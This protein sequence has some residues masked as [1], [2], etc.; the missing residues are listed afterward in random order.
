MHYQ[1]T[2]KIKE[3][4]DG[5]FDN[6][7]WMLMHTEKKKEIEE[8]VPYILYALHEVKAISNK[9]KSKRKNTISLFLYAEYGN[10]KNWG[11]YEKPGA[12]Q[13]NDKTV[14]RE[15]AAAQVPKA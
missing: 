6:L 11:L 9:E 8:K 12:W 5:T 14:A 3:K 15:E 7:H 4:D 2:K 1:K 13:M 10:L